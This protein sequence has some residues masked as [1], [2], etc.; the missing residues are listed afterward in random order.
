MIDLDMIFDVNL[1][2]LR[3][4]IVIMNSAS[5]MC[6]YKRGRERADGGVG[7]YV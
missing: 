1:R 6:I 5:N 2:K 4:L 7:V 3:L